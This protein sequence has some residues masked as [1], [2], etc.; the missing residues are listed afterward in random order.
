VSPAG[1]AR[2]G[3]DPLVAGTDPPVYR[4]RLRFTLAAS[5]L[6]AAVDLADALRR[7]TDNLVQVRPSAARLLSSQR[8]DVVVTT[9][10]ALNLSAVARLW[11]EEML[12]IAAANPGCELIG[13]TSIVTREG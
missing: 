9:I 7:G 11:A 6:R 1:S 3:G 2:P 8:W 12:R 5:S 13:W 10:P 4:R